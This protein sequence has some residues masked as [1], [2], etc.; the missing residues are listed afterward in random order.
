MDLWEYTLLKEGTY[1]L[2]SSDVLNNKEAGGTNEEAIVKPGY[3]GE[4]LYNGEIVGMVPQYISV[5]KGFNFIEVTNMYATFCT[6]S[7]L[8]IMPKIPNTVIMLRS[9][10][11]RC[12]NL[13][14]LS[15][16]PKNVIDMHGTFYNCSSIKVAPKIPDKVQDCFATFQGCTNLIT[17]TT[18]PISVLNARYMYADCPNLQGTLEINAN[19]NSEHM[20]DGYTNYLG[21]LIRSTTA[22]GISLKV[23]GKCPMLEVIVNG[24]ENPKITL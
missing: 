2:N 1:A 22:D 20:E 24:A 7:E 19:I 18:V 10:F 3:K 5:D 13:I 23:Y 12:K 17:G 21:L 8:K 15:L 11:S 9:T 6:I 16:I 4:C 14:T